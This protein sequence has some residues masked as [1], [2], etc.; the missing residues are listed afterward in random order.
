MRK[1]HFDITDKIVRR[2]V[3][4]FFCFNGFLFFK[5]REHRRERHWNMKHMKM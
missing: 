5:I 2:F 4:G 3:M 1:I